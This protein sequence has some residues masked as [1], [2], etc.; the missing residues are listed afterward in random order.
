MRL[1][2]RFEGLFYNHMITKGR[3]RDSAYYSIIDSEW[4]AIRANFDKWL[5]DDNFD[6][7]G[8]Q[9]TS[10]SALNRALW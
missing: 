1:G 7:H 6:S 2:F 9:R 10:L 5:A 8:R 3:S 4:P